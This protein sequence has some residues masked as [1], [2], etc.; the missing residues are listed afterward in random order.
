[1]QTI[2]TYVLSVTDHKPTRLKA[3]STSGISV[4]M[5]IHHP[6]IEADDTMEMHANIR[7]ELECKLGWDVIDDDWR[8]GT[9]R[10]GHIIWVMPNHRS[11]DGELDTLEP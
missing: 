7:Y 1:M 3:V 11:F 9:L 4:T 6:D 10:N 5:S 8:H 2:E